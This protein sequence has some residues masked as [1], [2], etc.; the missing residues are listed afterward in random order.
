MESQTYTII[1]TEKF[2]KELHQQILYVA[3]QFSKETALQIKENIQTSIL[4]L[5]LHPYMGNTPK[6]RN[7]KDN[8]F[9]MLILNK[10][11]I[12]YTVVEETKTIYLLSIVDQRQDY[13]N[14]LNGL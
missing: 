13:I 4:N 1:P 5:Q 11:I 8:D 14:I 12:F 7:L 6:I 2:N 9:R 10:L 3:M